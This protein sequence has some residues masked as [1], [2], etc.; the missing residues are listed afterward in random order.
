VGDWIRAQ[1]ITQ[2]LKL[3][4]QLDS[5]IRFLDF[6]LA[7]TAAPDKFL[8]YDWYSLYFV[9]SNKKA[10]DYL[11]EIKY[12]LDG[13]QK[14]V[15]VIWLS[16][17]GFNG[18]GNTFNTNENNMQKFLKEVETLFGIMLFDHFTRNINDTTIEEIINLNLRVIIYAGEYSHFI[19]NTRFYTFG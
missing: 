8:N 3:T 14:E 12:W 4:E 15:V 16:N 19:N 17:H 1:A 18:D 13:H 10:I 5:G 11:I 9:E 7:F 2:D 6:R